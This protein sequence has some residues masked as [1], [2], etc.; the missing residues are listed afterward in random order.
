MFT[1]IVRLSCVMW[2]REYRL[3]THAKCPSGLIDNRHVMHGDVTHFG[4][5]RA[6]G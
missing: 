5:S 2:V 4:P 6:N 3:L 1:R